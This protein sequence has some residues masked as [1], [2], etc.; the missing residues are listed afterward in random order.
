MKRIPIND[1]KLIVLW[2]FCD[3]YTVDQA[4]A[5]KQVTAARVRGWMDRYSKEVLRSM[6]IKRKIR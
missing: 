4:A 5:L 6:A 2:I 1:Q 3:K